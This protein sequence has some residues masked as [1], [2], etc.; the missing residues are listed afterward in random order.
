MTRTVYCIHVD[1]I[2]RGSDIKSEAYRERI[3]NMH[4][5]WTR[6]GGAP[7]VAMY[8]CN[9]AV[10]QKMP[11]FQ[12]HTNTRLAPPSRSRSAAVPPAVSCFSSS[13]NRMRCLR[14]YGRSF[15]RQRHVFIR[16]K[17]TM[18]IYYLYD[19]SLNLC[20]ARIR[21][22]VAD[23]IEAVPQIIIFSLQRFDIIQ[24][25]LHLQFPS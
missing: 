2:L 21:L 20:L 4:E 14:C 12:T 11:V 23:S 1:V 10:G 5:A 16:P 6:D 7:C 8:S 3:W 17:Y 13:S 9:V 25:I 24:C 18:L 19:C 22:W 15:S